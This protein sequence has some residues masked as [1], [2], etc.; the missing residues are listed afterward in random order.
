MRRVC[1]NSFLIF[2]LAALTLSK[3]RRNAVRLQRN[4]IGK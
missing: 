2:L 1:W 3:V 4:S